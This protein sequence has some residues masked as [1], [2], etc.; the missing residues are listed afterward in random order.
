M[1]YANRKTYGMFC[2]ILGVLVL[3]LP[4]GWEEHPINK[5]FWAAFFLGIGALCVKK[6]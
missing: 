2:L 1:I 5:L 4:A 3:V 6:G